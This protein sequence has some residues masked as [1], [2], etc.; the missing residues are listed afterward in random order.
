MA[1]APSLRIDDVA[2]AINGDQLVADT[3]VKVEFPGLV[4]Q[5]G[6]RRTIEFDV[7]S[8]PG[9]GK[10][11]LD[12]MVEKAHS[13]TRKAFEELLGLDSAVKA[14]TVGSLAA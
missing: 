1:H 12:K 13:Q 14:G 10:E 6:K 4:T 7:S 5:D 11:V 3:K 8:K 2:L 9:G